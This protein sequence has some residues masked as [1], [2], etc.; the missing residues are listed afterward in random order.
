MTFTIH[1][2]RDGE[3]VLT[4]RISP[5]VAVAKART[6]MAAG[7]TVHIVDSDGREYEPERF[8][9]LLSFDRRPIIK[10]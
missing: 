4:A 6:L 8:D 5:T 3:T 2:S 9:E 1:A 7:W 10:F